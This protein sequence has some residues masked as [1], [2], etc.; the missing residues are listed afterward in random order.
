MKKFNV[1]KTE[2]Y[3]VTAN[4]SDEAINVVSNLD[5]GSASSSNYDVITSYEEKE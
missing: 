3:W 5:S 1:V 2:H 4:N